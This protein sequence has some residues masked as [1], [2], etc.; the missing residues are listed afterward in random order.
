[1]RAWGVFGI[2]L[3]TCA[4]P[5]ERVGRLVKRRPPTAGGR[6][7]SPRVSSRSTSR[8]MRAGSEYLEGSGD[9]SGKPLEMRIELWHFA[10][11][12]MVRA[13]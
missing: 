10:S 8:L 13:R 7:Q 6:D 5:G 9:H 2:A 11:C 3:L 4:K 1:M 12:T